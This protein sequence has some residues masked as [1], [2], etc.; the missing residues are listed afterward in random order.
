M[1][2]L[3]LQ[4]MTDP[5]VAVDGAPRNDET[6]KD[7]IQVLDTLPAISHL[8]FCLLLLLVRLLLTTLPRHFEVGKN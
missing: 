7:P 5:A 1:S 2:R 3:L 8:Q 6:D 4:R